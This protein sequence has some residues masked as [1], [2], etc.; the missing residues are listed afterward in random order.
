MQPLSPG[1]NQLLQL[2]ISDK[3]QKII[4]N[5]LCTSKWI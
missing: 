1:R 5:C 4:V 3:L 2:D